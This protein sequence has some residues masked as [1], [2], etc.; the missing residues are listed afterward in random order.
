[1]KRVLILILCVLVVGC[2][3]FSSESG[4]DT[5]PAWECPSCHW[6]IGEFSTE[7]PNCRDKFVRR[8]DGTGH[9]PVKRE[10]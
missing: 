1:M 4:R 10:K 8:E 9:I 7:C 3:R 6:G 2:G 5:G